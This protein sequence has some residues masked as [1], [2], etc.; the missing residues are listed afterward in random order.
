MSIDKYT[1][2]MRRLKQNIGWQSVVGLELQNP[3]RQTQPPSAKQFR[4]NGNGFGFG[5]KIRIIRANMRPTYEPL[6]STKNQG[7]HCFFFPSL[8]AV[9]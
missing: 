2:E 1:T 4:I 8:L 6:K 7:A 5:Y 3:K 9:N